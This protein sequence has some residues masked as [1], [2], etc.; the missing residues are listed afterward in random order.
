MLNIE[1]DKQKF[2]LFPDYQH[3]FIYSVE[4]INESLIYLTYNNN[5]I[6]YAIFEILQYVFVYLTLNFS[7]SIEPEP[8]FEHSVPEPPDYKSSNFPLISFHHQVFLFQM[9]KN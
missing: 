4:I 8:K 1:A 3:N 7:S 6:I 2:H 5:S 9:R